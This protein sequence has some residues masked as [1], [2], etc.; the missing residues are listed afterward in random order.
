L[1]GGGF[2]RNIASAR[3]VHEEIE[4]MH[5]NPVRR[6]LC[7]RPTDWRYSSARFWAGETDIVL[8]MDRTLPAKYWSD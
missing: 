1:S 8:A 3:A 7:R 4:Y 5:G 6:G 2:D